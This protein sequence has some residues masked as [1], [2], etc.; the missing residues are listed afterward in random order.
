M[1]TC[2]QIVDALNTLASATT[3]PKTIMDLTGLVAVT[4][5]PNGNIT[6]V[7]LS[8]GGDAVLSVPSG[9]SIDG[10]LF[11]LTLTGYITQT[12]PETSDSPTI[13]IWNGANLSTATIVASVGANLPAA[14]RNF[15][16]V[17]NGFW[18]STTQRFTDG[19]NFIQT[20]AAQSDF[21]FVI[22]AQTGGASSDPGDILTFTT[23][24][25]ELV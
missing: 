12:T 17:F 18:D 5:V 1:P 7:Q 14:P 10:K 2:T 9:I 21:Q 22:S 24:L 4:S 8:A 11:R 15:T 6:K 13:R 16:L 20:V 19:T 3:N 25:F 23:V